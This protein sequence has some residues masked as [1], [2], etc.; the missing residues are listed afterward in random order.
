[1]E[2][3][4]KN[5][6]SGW[7]FEVFP[8]ALTGIELHHANARIH[9]AVRQAI[10]I[11]THLIT[12]IRRPRCLK[13]V[14]MHNDTPCN[15]QRQHAK[16]TNKSQAEVRQLC[17]PP[18][19][20]V[21]RARMILITRPLYKTSTKFPLGVKLIYTGWIMLWEWNMAL[22]EF[23]TR[24]RARIFAAASVLNEVRDEAGQK[25]SQVAQMAM[26]DGWTEVLAVGQRAKVPAVPPSGTKISRSDRISAVIKLVD[27]EIPELKNDLG[28]GFAVFEI[29]RDGYEEAISPHM[30]GNA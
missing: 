18:L 8:G 12:H 16:D 17:S 10:L 28:S 24:R 3:S 30:R 9:W 14:Q 7:F 4:T 11:S 5:Q 21:V 13:A 29:L 15:I 6:P 25:P 20:G 19:P 22:S 26:W 23:D 27:A 1:M 2:S